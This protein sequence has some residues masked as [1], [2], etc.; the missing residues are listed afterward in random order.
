MFE[1]DGLC[2]WYGRSAALRDFNLTM[3]RG[4]AVALMGHNGAGKSSLIRILA[5]LL[6]FERGAVKF[7]GRDLRATAAYVKRNVGVVLHEPLLYEG[8][9]ITENLNFAAAAFG[10]ADAAAQ[11][12]RATDL[13]GLSA[14][15]QRRVGALSNGMRRRASIA[16]AI[17]HQP[18]TLLLDEP[19]AGLDADGLRILTNL[20]RD[21]QA[22]G[23][24]VIVAS[25][26]AELLKAVCGRLIVFEN[27]AKARDIAAP[28]TADWSLAPRQ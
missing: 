23:K 10:V 22:A 28:Q 11:A 26:N 25:H 4:E 24:T 3:E 15:A 21:H 14:H 8:L 20:I 18:Q 13:L 9:T 19:D 7:A 16:R 12:A 2:K 27:G 5:T 17:I 6:R 1:I